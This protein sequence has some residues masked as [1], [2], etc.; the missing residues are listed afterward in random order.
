MHSSISCCRRL[1]FTPDTAAV[2]RCTATMACSL[3]RA[4]DRVSGCATPIDFCIAPTACLK[5]RETE[6][7]VA[8]V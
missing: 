3:S 1:K 4:T 7:M 5:N 6:V 2:L 8:V